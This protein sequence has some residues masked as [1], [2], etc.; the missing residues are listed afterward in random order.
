MQAIDNRATGIATK[1]D[2]GLGEMA[3]QSNT[4]RDALR[5]AVD[6][7]RDAA[8]E[9][10]MSTARKSSADKGYASRNNAEAISAIGAVP[11]ISFASHHR[12]NGGGTW[13]KC[14]TTS[15]SSAQTF[16]RIITSG[17]I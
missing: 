10:Q 4:N 9:K 3:Q 2:H 17:A 11:Y 12:G 8:T 14:I 15:S 7:K 5:Q 16:S 6:A 1:L 13:K